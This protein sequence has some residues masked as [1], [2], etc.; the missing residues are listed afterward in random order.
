M[1]I[2]FKTKKLQ[3]RCNSL[4]EARKKWGPVSGEKLMQRLDELDAAD[5]LLDTLNLP[6]TYHALTGDRAGQWGVGL[7]HPMRLIFEPADEPLPLL[8]DDSL[9][10]AAVKVVRILEIVDYH[11]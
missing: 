6:G 7:K 9:N 11:G 3:K 2:L 4:E 8:E 5:S 10:I 1:I